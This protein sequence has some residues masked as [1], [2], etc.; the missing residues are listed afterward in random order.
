MSG[1]KWREMMDER[2]QCRGKAERQSAGF[3]GSD[4]EEEQKYNPD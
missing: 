2:F 3:V 1:R 4:E